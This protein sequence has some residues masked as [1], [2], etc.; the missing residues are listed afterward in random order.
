MIHL[1]DV[2]SS[3]EIATPNYAHPHIV[4]LVPDPAGG[5]GP[6][7]RTFSVTTQVEF[8]PLQEAAIDA[9][10]ATGDPLDK[11]RT[12]PTILTSSFPVRHCCRSNRKNPPKTIRIMLVEVA[13]LQDKPLLDG[14]IA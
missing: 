4:P 14:C 8:A 1:L 7:V 13:E 5:S 11:V 12:D 2:C 9:Y 10:V 3:L 6:L